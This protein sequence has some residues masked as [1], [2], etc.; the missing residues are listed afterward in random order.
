MRTGHKSFRCPVEESYVTS[1]FG[2]RWMEG[3]HFHE[4][5]DLAADIGTPIVAADDGVVSYAGWNG[6][7]GNLMTIVHTNGYTTRYVCYVDRI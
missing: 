4:G 5:V 6:G 1:G 3:G 7:Y 2:W